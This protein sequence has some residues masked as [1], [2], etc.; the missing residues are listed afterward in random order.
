MLNQRDIFEKWSADM[1]DQFGSLGREMIPQDSVSMWVYRLFAGLL[2]GLGAYAFV[3]LVES[4]SQPLAQLFVAFAL[5][6]TL[7][8]SS[9]LFSLSLAW[10]GY[11]KR[12][13]EARRKGIQA[14][15]GQ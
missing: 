13:R 9:Y 4:P 6:A 3:L 14:G 2:F 11:K 1:L 10:N 8:I 15:T 7:V 5:L 12:L